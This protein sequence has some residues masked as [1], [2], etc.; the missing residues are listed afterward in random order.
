MAR[1]AAAMSEQ[2]REPSR[3]PPDKPPVSQATDPGATAADDLLAA[4]ADEFASRARRGERPIV[5][6]YIAKHPALAE[7]IRNIFPAIAVI[8]QT[9]SADSAAVGERPGSIIGRYKLLE[10][11]GEGGFGV[12]YMAEQQL[13]V[14]RKVA[15]KVLKPGMDSRQVLAR[16]EAERQALAIMDHPNIAK[17]FDGGMTDSGRP[18]FVMELAKGVP[19]TDFCDLQHL[20]PRERLALFAHVCHAVQH[21]HQKGIIHR[22]IKPSN[23]L[24]IM[25]DTTP[26]V[27]VIDFGVAK[28]LGQELTEKT[29]FTGFAQLVGTPLYM[30]PEQAGQSALDVDTRSDIYSLGV[31]LYELLTGSTPFD[32]DRL[33]MAAQDEVRRI[34]R[35][36]EP[37]TP[38]TRLSQ[39]KDSLASISAQRQTEPAKLT[40]L[41][42]GELDWIVMKAL[43]KDRSRRYETAN[44]LAMD[45][46]RYLADEPVLACPPSSVYRMKKFVRRNKGALTV[47]ALALCVLVLL[48]SG[49]GWI[50]RDR[51][52]RQ[53]RIAAQ[54]ELILNEVDALQTQ[55]KWPEALA[56]TRRA[57]A[58]IAAGE[59]DPATALRVREQLKDLEF[60]DRLEQARMLQA[61]WVGQAFD[62]VTADRAYAQAFRDYG[63][64][65]D[66]LAVE[67]SIKRIKTRPKLTVAVAVALDAW[68]GARARINHGAADWKRLID[69][70][71]GIDPEPVRDR[72]RATLGRP[73][74]EVRDE[75]RWLAESIDVRAHAPAT[76]QRLARNL[77]QTNQMDVAVQL[78]RDAQRV[79]PDDFWLNYDLGTI[80][81]DQ[82]DYDGAARFYTAAVSI[83]P[84][85]VAAIN[86]LGNVLLDQKKL[87]EAG[88]MYRRATEVDPNFVFG[89]SNLGSVLRTT[90]KLDESAAA[91]QRAIEI[92]PNFG[93]LYSNLGNVLHEQKKL[94]EAESA[95][96]KAIELDPANPRPYFGLGNV[97]VDRG[98]FDEAVALY[99][100]AIERDP[101]LA[102]IYANLGV[103][104]L[105]QKDLDGA[106]AAFQKAIE[107]NPANAGTYDALG[108][109]LVGQGKATEAIAAYRNAI[110][111]DAIDAS[112][113]DNLGLAFAQLKEFSKANECFRKAIDLDPNRARFHYNLGMSFNELK[114]YAR[115]VECF[116]KT[117]AL[118]PEFPMGYHAL[119]VACYRAGDFK[120]AIAALD[121]S[122]QLRNG[123]GGEDWF[124]L[125]MAHCQL[126][127][128]DEA[129]RWYER[130]V[131]WMEK[132]APDDPDLIRFRAEAAGLLGVT[133]IEQH[134]PSIVPT[135][136]TS[137]KV[138]D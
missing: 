40:K 62:S 130:G 117:V 88:A 29:L 13:P 121:E 134:V 125:A 84:H 132:N 9:R 28:A 53:G 128:Q 16:F 58:I 37:P 57:E 112:Y 61:A 70:A 19:I 49:V 124:F 123:E 45:V 98:K 100:K 85:A 91:Y 42:R 129:R 24:V 59:A 47:A 11:I 7:R 8:E 14:R 56:A 44:G 80:L 51:Q 81:W 4:L 5:D 66:E 36:E 43:E 102:A 6:E 41:V 126:G 104:L 122:M 108:T 1:G 138:E 111:R 3:H 25:H 75:L 68:F 39:S 76:I 33:K 21:A 27:K 34:I 52:A 72:I 95:Y 71:R 78:L 20:A 92:D 89:H 107:L 22:D 23:V 93:P 74:A 120:A 94:E 83:R 79:H 105:R 118:E 113:H 87:D 15:L 64:D 116:H 67:E 2:S 103:I 65:V 73:T 82:K 133:P 55:Q 26:V 106:I 54:V 35:E 127:D 38:S 18:Y 119:G 101:P 10:R 96:R 109:A 97:F 90:G 77:R 12:V 137:Q 131:G 46:Q 50:V 60:I 99:R 86:D 30:S 69:V 17:V 31:L 48:G 63:V 135:T 32:K 110:E 136:A 114:E 115:A